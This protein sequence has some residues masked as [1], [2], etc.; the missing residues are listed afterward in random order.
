MRFALIENEQRIAQGIR[1]LRKGLTKLGV[2]R[3]SSRPL[4]LS[5]SRADVGR[6][7]T[8][9]TVPTLRRAGLAARPARRPRA[10]G[11][12]D[13]RRA[14]RRRRASRSSS[15]AAAG[16]STSSSSTL[17]EDGLVDLLVAEIGQV[18]GVDVEDVRTVD[19][20][21][22]D[23]Q[24]A[25]LESARPLVEA[26]R[27]AMSCSTC[28]ART[29]WS[30]SRATGRSSLDLE[31]TVA[32]GVAGAPARGGVARRLPRRQPAS[33][34]PRRRQGR[35]RR[36]GVGRARRSWLAVAVGRASRPFRCR[37]RRQLAALGPHRRRRR[38]PS[39][40]G[41][42]IVRTPECRHDRGPAPASARR[43]AATARRRRRRRCGRRG[44]RTRRRAASAAATSSSD[45]PHAL[46]QPGEVGGAE[47]GGLL[48]RGPADGHAELVGLQLQQQVHHRRPAVDPQRRAPRRPDALGHRVDH[49]AGL[50]R[51]R[52]DH[53]PGEVGAGRAAGDADDRCRGR[54]DP[55]TGCR[56]R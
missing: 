38:W 1:N 2:R 24:L 52:L 53:G 9:A 36:P 11:E 26:R 22:H 5:R 14:R 32:V 35:P 28:C 39:T 33:R 18:D 40:G 20:D 17:P 6:L 29:A 43:R 4:S 37:E 27:R 42:G 16:P 15:G 45:A 8:F 48:A 12:P 41:A 55:T 25:A 30:T 23:R 3:A 49:V 21:R 7:G 44:R 10:G 50:V 56:G 54:T 51:H 19:P 34:R 31:H 47:R 13:R 46:G